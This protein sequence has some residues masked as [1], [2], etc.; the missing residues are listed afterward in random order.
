MSVTGQFSAVL[1]RSGVMHMVTTGLETICCC[2][3]SPHAVATNCLKLDFCNFGV[4]A[5]IVT[6]KAAILQVFLI[7][8][9]LNPAQDV[10]LFLSIKLSKF[11]HTVICKSC[12]LYLRRPF[13]WV[14]QRNTFVK[15]FFCSFSNQVLE[16]CDVWCCS[17]P[18]FQILS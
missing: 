2:R 15:E 6:R 5:D 13:F 17:L 14:G 7:S 8:Q 18:D 16:S 10:K 12:R 9:N 1:Q 3:L 4:I 11:I